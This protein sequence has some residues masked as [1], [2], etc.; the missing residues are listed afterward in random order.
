MAKKKTDETELEGL[1]LIKHRVKEM[2]TELV[3]LNAALA[4]L[5]LVMIAIPQQFNDFIGQILGVALCIWGALRC[6][7]FLRLK[8]DEAF[9][10]YALVQ[11]A[12][13]IGFG[14]FFLVQKESFSNLLN[15][16]LALIILIVAVLKLQNA[17]NYFKLKIKNWWLHLIAALVLIV[18]GVI[19]IIRPGFVDDDHGLLIVMTVIMGCAL[20]ISGIW[21]IVSV[22][23]M[24]KAI[25]KTAKELE[26]EGKLPQTNKSKNKVVKISEKDVTEKKPSK[27]QK[28]A[29]TTSFSD[30]ELD[31]IDNLDYGDE[32]DSKK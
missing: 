7:H 17:I 16:A 4:V 11:G 9:G 32:F 13:M 2:K 23:I 28:N 24:S 14:I 1:D 8:G 22:M 12:A 30:P 29:E 27:K 19:A 20:V 26:K 6:I 25:K 10:S 15:S 21:D 3:I 18:F 31:E 5:G